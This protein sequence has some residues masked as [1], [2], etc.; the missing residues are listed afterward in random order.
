MCTNSFLLQ[1]STFFL[2]T[3]SLFLLL[4]ASSKS[5][6]HPDHKNALQ[7][8]CTSLDDFSPGCNW[9]NDKVYSKHV[10]KE[11]KAAGEWVEKFIGDKK[12]PEVEWGKKDLSTLC[13]VVPNK[14][15][16]RLISCTVHSRH[17]VDLILVFGCLRDCIHHSFLKRRKDGVYVC[18]M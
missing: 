5:Q 14:Y 11:V 10:G 15:A 16:V 7:F 1:S 9:D 18:V 4:Q 6:L 13:V 12:W 3:I 17:L 8:V 2:Y